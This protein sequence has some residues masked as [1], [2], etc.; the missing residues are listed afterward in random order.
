MH[1]YIPG[2]IKDRANRRRRNHTHTYIH[3]YIH[4]YM[5]TYQDKSKIALIAVG[6][7]TIFGTLVGALIYLYWRNRKIYTE[8]RCVW[9]TYIHIH[10]RTYIHTY[11][12]ERTHSH[13]HTK[14]RTIQSYFSISPVQTTVLEK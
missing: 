9:S 4:T 11:T 13:I 1:A 5:H 8:Y 7:C 6:G 10:I 12:R 3:T 14:S 2:Q